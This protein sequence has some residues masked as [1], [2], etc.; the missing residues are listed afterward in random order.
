MWRPFGAI[1]LYKGELPKIPFFKFIGNYY[2][3]CKTVIYLTSSTIYINYLTILPSEFTKI[4]KMKFISIAIFAVSF[5][6][7]SEA[8]LTTRYLLQITGSKSGN[9]L[10]GTLKGFETSAPA[11]GLNLTISSPLNAATGQVSGKRHYNP[12]VV[13][14]YI[15]DQSPRVIQALITNERLTTIKLTVQSVQDTGIATSLRTYTFT[16]AQL[17]GVEHKSGLT[18]LDEIL[19]FNFQKWQLETTK[20]SIVVQDTW[21][22]AV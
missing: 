6:A 17:L 13:S 5:L 14:R 10:K 4:F 19:T 3:V 18:D 1:L 15:D 2:P 11:F 7:L 22:A 9:I 16:N 8:A 20:G 12:I 21:S